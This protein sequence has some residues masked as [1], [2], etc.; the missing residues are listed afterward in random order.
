MLI[1]FVVSNFLSFNE[2]T[3]FNMLTG[4]VRT[5]TSHVSEVNNLKVLR[6]AA[7]YGANGA[8]KSNLV[9]ALVVLHDIV[10]GGDW[11]YEEAWKPFK[12]NPQNQ[13]KPASFEVEFA[14]EGNVYHYGISGLKTTI[15]EEWLYKVHDQD[16]STCV[17]DRKTQQGKTAITFQEKYLSTP[18]GKVR[19]KLYADEL[20]QDNAS[21]LK[22]MAAGKEV[23]PEVKQAYDWFRDKLYLL[24][25]QSKPLGLAE[26][27]TISDEFKEFINDVIHSL[28]TGI[29]ALEV[30]TQSLEDFFGTNEQEE[31]AK[32]KAE[33]EATG[34]MA[35]L[36]S[37][38]G[39]EELVFMEENG[40]YFVKQ[41]L[42]KHLTENGEEVTFNVQE[43]SDGTVRLLELLP[44]IFQ[45]IQEGHVIIIDE[46]GRSIHPWL[47][48][49][50]LRKFSA[51]PANGQLIFTTHEA[52]LLDQEIF[53]R[54]EIWLTEKTSKGATSLSPLSDFDIR[55]DL[56]IRKGY[57]NGRFGAIPLLANLQDLN[58]SQ[59]A[60]EKQGV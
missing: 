37:L 34:S 40:G 57:L 52:H 35:F 60:T 32:I 26:K 7:I 54:D 11:E 39:K 4:N 41:L 31:V 53:R 8:G 58:W 30:E 28:D 44:A 21:L 20:L 45:A 1:R 36:R 33:L 49:S 24:F 22:L 43:E 56:D 5:L 59:Y 18:E 15:S 14:Y 46:I 25:P 48:K 9:K 17:F 42:T 12:L 47:L 3:E 55:V 16:H 27:L 50:L 19:R 38:D 13:E 10:V 29:H 51:E 6:S 23:F 2:E